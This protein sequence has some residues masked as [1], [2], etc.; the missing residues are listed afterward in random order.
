MS[1]KLATLDRHVSVPPLEQ[2]RFNKELRRDDLYTFLRKNEFFSI[3]NTFLGAQYV[4]AAPSVAE[5]QTAHEKVKQIQGVT[6]VNDAASAKRVLAKL[7]ALSGPE[8]VFACDTEVVG[9]DL[10]VRSP[11]GQG[12]VICASIYCGPQHDF[13]NGPRIWI[14]NL[15]AAEGTLG[16]LKPFW[17]SK[18]HKKVWHNIGFDR[19]V[20][21]NEGIDVVGFAG[22]TMHMARL[23]DS[24]R[25]SYS[26]ETLSEELLVDA[27]PKVGMKVRGQ[28]WR[29]DTGL[30]RA[31]AR[32]RADSVWARGHVDRWHGGQGAH[33]SPAG[34]V[35]A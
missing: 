3:L 20:M 1:L 16:L 28:W 2:L 13:G 10:D 27:T 34:G 5:V 31:R 26:L 22:D 25:R 11:V 18:K 8:H 14:D 29:L 4:P 7:M 15:D 17:E 23:W 33:S 12:K 35:A 6:I 19:H 9:L 30:I 24:S 21:F 32:V